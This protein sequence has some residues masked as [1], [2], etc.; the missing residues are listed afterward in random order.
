GVATPVLLTSPS[1]VHLGRIIKGAASPS[2]NINVN[3]AGGAATTYAVSAVSN[4][5]FTVADAGNSSV[6]IT[7]MGHNT[8][9]V[10]AD[11]STAGSK[12]ASVTVAG[13]AVAMDA[14]V[15]EHANGTF[16]NTTGVLSSGDKVLT[17]D[18]GTV[19]AGTSGGNIDSSFNIYA[20][21]VGVATANLDLT[22]IVG[23]LSK[24]TGASTF[25]GL[26]AGNNQGYT[27]HFNTT[28]PGVLSASYT[29]NLADEAGVVG[30]STDTLTLNV[31]GIVTFHP[32]DVNQDGQVGL[33]DYNVIK[34][35]FGASYGS[36]NHWTDGDVNGDLQVGLLDFN[37]VKA[38]FGHT[39]GDGAAVTAVPEPATMSL[40]AL[41]GLAALRRKR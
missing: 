3:E 2:Q 26:A 12:S 39:T 15:L 37:I 4:S 28:T 7:A 36:G 41:A 19:A 5:D 38:H 16:A 33:L 14:T 25:A 9:A 10:T 30:G 27:F 32:G 8:H 40:L 13:T 34:A 11:T 6:A 21:V 24:L 23:D 18:F 35:N 1:T 20:N 31:S 17:L 29:F 22:G